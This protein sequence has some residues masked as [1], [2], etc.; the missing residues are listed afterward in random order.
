MCVC[1]FVCICVCAQSKY[2]FHFPATRPEGRV[3]G[4]EDGGR[5]MQE[6][7]MYPVLKFP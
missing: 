3:E 6:I 5:G 4:M 1:V 2:N 7:Q